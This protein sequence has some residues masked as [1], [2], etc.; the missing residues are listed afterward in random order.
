MSQQSAMDIK[1]AEMGDAA[2]QNP[3]MME[4]RSMIAILNGL[5]DDFGALR[6]EFT[7]FKQVHTPQPVQI[8]QE[9]KE[10]CKEE[11]LQAFSG[12]LQEDRENVESIKKQLHQTQLQNK[13]LAEVVDN[14]AVQLKDLNTR[15]DSVELKNSKYCA[16]LTG[17][18]ARDGKKE[19]SQDV[20]IFLK[21]TLQV[22]PVID[23]IYKMGSK[24]PKPIIIIFRSLEEKRQI[25]AKKSELN[26][27]VNEEERKFYLQDFQPM[28][29]VEKRKRE[30]HIVS[31]NDKKDDKEKLIIEQTKGGITIQG[32]LYRKRVQVPTPREMY[33]ITLEDYD[34]M[35]H[36]KMGNGESIE[37]MNSRFI[38]YTKPTNTHH[39]I[40]QLYKR[41]KL[42]NPGARHIVCA[43][44]IDGKEDHYCRDFCDDDEP[45]AG[46]IVLNW[47]EK[48]N[49]KNR[50]FFLVRYYGNIKM[51]ADRFRCYIEAAKSALNN[52][53][54]N[55]YTNEN[56][57]TKEVQ[58]NPQNTSVKKFHQKYERPNNEASLPIRGQGGRRSRSYGRYQG[59]NPRGHRGQRGGSYKPKPWDQESQEP[60]IKFQFNPPL[61]KNPNNIGF[62]EETW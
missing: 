21:Q 11:A 2:K 30:R 56:Q 29:Q 40:R 58:E 34:A 5:K 52:N 18:R 9:L 23:D 41:M 62:E 6:K 53:P 45:G 20:K 60:P 22:Q 49:L 25:M 37:E 39:E 33:D 16:M 61:E 8:D 31:E 50:V 28:N 59:Y 15:M 13:V 43:Y 38:A 7:E 17:L 36:T 1:G 24:E 19:L 54:F 14:L 27:F 10:K 12:D 44:W 4:V 55:Y 48:C 57:E 46:R 47:M 3:E 51:G 35:M 26:K 32:N 42:Q